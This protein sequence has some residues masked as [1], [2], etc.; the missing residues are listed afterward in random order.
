MPTFICPVNIVQK[1]LNF[2]WP[3]QAR[4][5]LKVLETEKVIECVERGARNKP[6]QKGRPTLWRYKLPMQ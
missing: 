6:G 4:L 2:R 5:L 3:E 1:F